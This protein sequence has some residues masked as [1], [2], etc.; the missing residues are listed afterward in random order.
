[1]TTSTRPWL[2]AGVLAAVLCALVALATLLGTLGGPRLDRATGI[3]LIML[4]VVVGLK[5]FVGDSGIFSFG[6]V[7]FMGVGAYTTAIVMMA[8]AQRAFQLPELPGFLADLELSAFE[9]ALLSGVVAAVFALLV[10]LPLMRL[11]GLTASLATVALLITCHSVLQNADRFTRGSGGLI[12]IVEPPALLTLLVCACVTIV[13]ALAFRQSRIGLRL[14][15]S[16]EDEVAARAIGVRVWWERG[17]AFVVSAFVLGVAGSLFVRYVGSINPDSF[18][19]SLTFTAI[20][21]LVVG[22]L[23]SVSGAVIGTIV[24][25]VALE[26]LRV[27]ESGV[28]IGGLEIPSR[29]GLASVGLALVLLGVLLLRPAGITGGREL[30]ELVPRRSRRAEQR[31]AEPD[32]RTG[33]PPV[34]VGAVEE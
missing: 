24:V 21:M 29:S 23:T 3:A 17:I 15:A 27:I 22:G 31:P 10:S 30:S 33:P 19:L 34:P 13:A 8:P 32:A 6:H 7:A 11:S 1:M 2:R 25:S 12:L 20:A 18:F 28:T 26:V 16:R 9:A 5:I 4:I 14:A